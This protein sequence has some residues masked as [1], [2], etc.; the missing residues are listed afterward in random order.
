MIDWNI[1]G[2]IEG[3]LWGLSMG[4]YGG[5]EIGLSNGSK[6]R[7]RY[8]NLDG[9]TMEESLG[10]GSGIWIGSYDGFSG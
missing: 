2:K 9:S 3:Y 5:A 6:D 1:V 4:T 10:T 8:F 7:I